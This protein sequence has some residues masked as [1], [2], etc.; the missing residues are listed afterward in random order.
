LN[1]LRLVDGDA[2]ARGGEAP[3]EDISDDYGDAAADYNFSLSDEALT[4]LD[5]A[6]RARLTLL[7]FM[8]VSVA[9]TTA[10]IATGS[11]ALWLSRQ[12]ATQ[13]AL[14]DVAA[15]LKSCQAR[16]QQLEA[17]VERLPGKGA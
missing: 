10:A 4:P 15:I 16:M 11:Y 1:R 3:P 12:Q 13:R 8:A 9:C 17:D 2:A 7:T 14:T 6:R 5:D